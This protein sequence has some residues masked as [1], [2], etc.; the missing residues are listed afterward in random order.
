MTNSNLPELPPIGRR[1]RESPNDDEVARLLRLMGGSSLMPMSTRARSSQSSRGIGRRH[2]SWAIWLVRSFWSAKAVDGDVA[3][4][5]S[6]QP[7]KAT[8]RSSR[9]NMIRPGAMLLTRSARSF[10]FRRRRRSRTTW[11]NL[12]RHHR[13]HRNA[14]QVPRVVDDAFLMSWNDFVYVILM[15][16][17][18]FEA[19]YLAAVPVID[20]LAAIE[21][22]TTDD[23]ERLRNQIPQSNVS[24]E[25]FFAAVGWGWFAPLRKAHYFAA[26]D[27]LSP[28]SDGLVCTYSGP[29]GPTG[30]CRS[31]TGLR[32]RCRE[33]VRGS[34]KGHK[35]IRPSLGPM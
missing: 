32:S 14:L 20:Q 22:P 21:H 25:R 28:N 33:C 27:P 19:S 10:G 29:Q 16:G 24:L 7:A 31:G 30:P 23:C 4:R 11:R 6:E 26:A 2:T 1:H 3:F 35:G 12:A 17:S 9:L 13:A 34:E 15:V 8:P 18:R 5:S